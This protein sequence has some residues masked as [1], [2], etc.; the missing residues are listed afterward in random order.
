MIKIDVVIYLS[1]NSVLTDHNCNHLELRV[2]VVLQISLNFMG[3]L[4]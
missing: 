4:W 2:E 1:L 3:T